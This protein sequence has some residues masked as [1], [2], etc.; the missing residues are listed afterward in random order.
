MSSASCAVMNSASHVG[1]DVVCAPHVEVELACLLPASFRD[2]VEMQI[3]AG[4]RSGM[5]SEML[6]FTHTPGL[7]QLL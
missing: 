5:R 6:W 1:A 3:L 7:S 4:G 2:S